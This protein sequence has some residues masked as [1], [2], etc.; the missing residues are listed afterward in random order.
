MISDLVESLLCKVPKIYLACLGLR[1]QYNCEKA[2][3]LKLIRSGFVLVEVGA[4]EG[5]FTRLFGN[6]V[7]MNGRV[8]AFEPIKKTRERLLEN[9]NHI[10]SIEVFPYA[11]S[12]KVGEF[13]MF[14]PGPTHGMASLRQHP[15]WGHEVSTC[16][17]KVQC[18]PLSQ[19]DD[20]KYLDKL[21]F[22]KIDAEGAELEILKGAQDILERDHPILHLEI[23]ESW[24]KS[25]GYGA[26]EIE[27]FLR[28]IGYNAF[29]T[30]DHE[31]T[32][33][34]SL[35]GIGSVNVVCSQFSLA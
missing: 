1:G 20:F 33:L 9:V 26:A 5:Y 12:E 8:L 19:L 30:Y 22:M 25:F 24:M 21:D 34:K 27:S 10:N 18:L 32:T 4:N 6:L 35:I 13:A 15:E 2:A 7:G 28:D 14:I 29:M 31:W 16:T 23:E 17:E 11:I 3:Y